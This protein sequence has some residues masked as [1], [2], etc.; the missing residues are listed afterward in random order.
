[1]KKILMLLALPFF[2]AC[3]AK[4]ESLELTVQ[5]DPSWVQ[6]Y[7]NA[8]QKVMDANPGTKISI[9][10]IGAFDLLQKVT[11]TDITNPDVTDLFSYPLDKL[12]VLSGKE[13]LASFDAKKLA[14]K[15]GGFDDYDNGLGGKLVINGNYLG[16]P[17][18]IET[19]VTFYNKKN[20]EINNVDLTKKQEV[21]Q[22]DINTIT[23]PI[24]NAWYA[25]A[26]LNSADIDLLTK[27]DGKFYSDMTKDFDKLTKKEKDVIST[28]YEYWKKATEQKATLFDVDATW[29]YI[30]EQFKNGN[31]GVFRIDGPWAVPSLVGL[32]DDLDV[33]PIGIITVKGVPIRHWKSGWAI[34]INA[35]IEENN[36]K[37]QLAEQ[38][39][40]EIL[41]PKTADIYF[42]QT[43]KIMPN[44]SKEEFDK[45]DLKDMDKKVIAAVI[46]SYKTAADV[47]TEKE[48]SRV[49]ETW[50]HAILSWDISKPKNVKEAYKEIKASFDAM[51][52][53]M[54]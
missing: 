47:P 25:I 21:I 6:Y 34:G 19:L 15:I 40:A 18:N 17:T 30:D 39:I 27:K 2:I 5:A 51:M 26:L 13:A 32:T 1:M 52:S 37:M 33:L 48:W 9:V 14:E 23:L 36:K 29:G 49:W 42:K 35:R 45:L 44:V 24:F 31:K 41:N 50:Q 4:E 22:K 28:L 54:E 3:G 43:G 11:E 20:A 16:F 38:F 10:E 46:D 12:T 8:A 53:N 7:Q